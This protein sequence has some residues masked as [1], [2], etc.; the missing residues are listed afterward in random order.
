MGGGEIL[1]IFQETVFAFD[2]HVDV[3]VP[4]Q[5]PG[6]RSTNLIE[7]LVQVGYQVEAIEDVQRLGCL[8]LDHF[9]VRLPQIRADVED[10][11]ALLRSQFPEKTQER[12]Y[13]ALIEYAQ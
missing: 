10:L 6:F 1:R 12:F 8:F 2:Q 11:A 3:A 7:G 4:L 5:S 13:V 9:E